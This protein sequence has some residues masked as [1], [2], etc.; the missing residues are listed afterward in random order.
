MFLPLFLR[1]R[2]ALIGRRVP[3]PAECAGT[4]ARAAMV[5]DGGVDAWRRSVAGVA[6]ILG[7][8]GVEVYLRAQEKG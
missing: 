7:R 4:L 2:V 1:L 3:Y 5:C 8:M 6:N